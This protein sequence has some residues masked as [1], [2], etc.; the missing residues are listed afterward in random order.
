MIIST[1]ELI[2]NMFGTQQ[3][4]FTKQQVISFGIEL[5]KIHANEALINAKDCIDISVRDE[6]RDIKLP[7]LKR[8]VLKCYQ[9]QIK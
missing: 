3:M 7:E 1:E 9:N 5:A 4:E 8:K 6:N 2:Y